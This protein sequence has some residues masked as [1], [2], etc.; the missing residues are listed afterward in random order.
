MRKKKRSLK[1]TIFREVC[2]E[3]FGAFFDG[4]YLFSTPARKSRRAVCP[5][6]LQENL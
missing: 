2:P 5:S 1:A 4:Y 6:V 3:K